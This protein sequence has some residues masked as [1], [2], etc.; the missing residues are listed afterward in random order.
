MRGKTPSCQQVIPQTFSLSRVL[1]PTHFAGYILFVRSVSDTTRR[2]ATDATSGRP[3]QFAT[4]WFRHFPSSIPG[5]WLI[6]R[7]TRSAQQL[8]CV[9]DF[10]FFELFGHLP[11]SFLILFC[12]LWALMR[13]DSSFRSSIKDITALAMLAQRDDANSGDV[14]RVC[15]SGFF[16]DGYKTQVI[17]D[18]RNFAT[19]KFG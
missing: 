13:S 17:G 4:S 3:I 9:L 15:G 18:S 2:S 6:C 14:P 11:P 12:P 7:A 5:R 8:F 16:V 10:V 19:A 1:Q